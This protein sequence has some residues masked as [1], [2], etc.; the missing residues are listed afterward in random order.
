MSDKES[1]GREPAAPRSGTGGQSIIR[2]IGSPSVYPPRAETAGATI[3]PM[4]VTVLLALVAACL[5]A[6]PASSTVGSGLHGLVKVPIGVCLDGGDCNGGASGV[7]LA[8]STEGRPVKRAV[9]GGNGRYR[10]MLRPGTY[11]V[12]APLM[13]SPRVR[14]VPKTVR[15]VKGSIRR[16][17]FLVDTGVRPP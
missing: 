3:R 7:M 9:S 10:I 13:E 12:T 11:T 8:F 5:A 1:D 14:V 2:R 17:D 16:V 6:A 15:V 4:R